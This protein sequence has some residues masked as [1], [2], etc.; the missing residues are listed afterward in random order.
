GTF[1]YQGTSGSQT[2][3]AA[4]YTNLTLQ[5]AATKSVPAGLFVSGTY[6]VAGGGRS[7]AGTFTYNGGDGSVQSVIGG[8]SYVS[9]SIAGATD[10]S[11][12]SYK[13]ATGTFT[14]SSGLTV[15]SGNTLDMGSFTIN[16]L[17][18]SVSTNSGKVRWAAGNVFVKVL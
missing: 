5:D 3:G 9:L 4:S 11:S 7:Y 2:V 1:I 18:T 14:V 8:E 12:A 10:T 16:S 15:N 6:S 17:D 13:L